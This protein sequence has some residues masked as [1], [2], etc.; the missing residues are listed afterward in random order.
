MVYKITNFK[1]IGLTTIRSNPFLK[2]AL[3]TPPISKQRYVITITN[4][5]FNII[6]EEILRVVYTPPNMIA[7][8]SLFPL[9]RVWWARYLLFYNFDPNGSLALVIFQ[10]SLA[11]VAWLFTSQA[12]SPRPPYILGVHT[13]LHLTKW[14]FHLTSICS[15]KKIILLRSMLSQT[16]LGTL[17]LCIVYIGI[18]EVIDWTKVAIP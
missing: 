6:N 5:L 14:S 17:K 8:C 2:L 9:S 18:V 1:G 12:L 13:F 11:I 15:H 4:R 10:P 3:T 16:F 7:P